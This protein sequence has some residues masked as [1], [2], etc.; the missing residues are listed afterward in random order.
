[1]SRI[2]VV[3]D[4]LP[5][6]DRG[7]GQAARP[8][9]HHEILALMGP[10]TRRGRHA[11]LPASRRAERQLV[12]RPVD[13]PPPGEGLPR[14]REVLALEVSERGNFR[15]VRSLTANPGDRDASG[16]V[17]ELSASGRDPEDL[18]EQIERFLYCVG[19]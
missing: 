6:V 5:A 4:T 9:T 16:P 15:L 12:F 7:S 2:R 8:L 1:M 14:L 13:H 3:A 10:F 18:L 11:D 17:A 19:F